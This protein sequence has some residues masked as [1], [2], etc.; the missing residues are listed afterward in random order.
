MSNTKT[1]TIR[2]CLLSDQLQ[3]R[4]ITTAILFLALFFGVVILSY[5]LLPEGF[6]AKKNAVTGFQTSE[7]IWISAIQIFAFNL[8]S[9][10]F[11]IIGSLF[12]KRKNETQK[13]MG[14]GY[15]C[16]FLL[17]ALNAVTLGT[18]SFSGNLESVPLMERI[19]GSFL[20]T[21]NAGLVEMLGQM[22]IC[23]ALANKS[24]VQVEN[25]EVHSQK[26][27]ENP[28]CKSEWI[29]LLLG[30]VLMFAGAY[31]ESRAMHG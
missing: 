15:Y 12:S 25:K 1:K 21:K 11:I 18:W 26:A 17:V 4:L 14:F 2:G 23:C 9:V 7:N 3:I 13:Y 28:L 31:I 29:V 5:Y 20:L 8:V 27:N 30:F 6:L 22:F 24:L 19:V 16:F 10:V